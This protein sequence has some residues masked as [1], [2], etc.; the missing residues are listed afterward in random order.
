MSRVIALVTCAELP[1]GDAD[2]RLLI[3]PLARIGIEAVPA[4]WDD[5]GVDWAAFDLAIIRSC[6]DYP[7]R[8]TEFLEWAAGV[9]CVANPYR[10]LEWNTHKRYLSELAGAGIPIVPTQ[11]VEA[12]DCWVPAS[13]EATGR[14]VIKPAVSL[15]ARDSGCYEL[16][17]TV[18]LRLAEQHVQRIQMSGRTVMIQP[19]LSGI[20]IYGETSLVYFGRHISHAVRKGAVL[21]GPDAGIDNLLV[22]DDRVLRRKPPDVAELIV[23]ERALD[24]VPGSRDQLLYARVDIV[25]GDDGAPCHYGTRAHRAEFFPRTRA[26]GGRALRGGNLP[27]ARIA[28]TWQCLFF[29]G[30]QE[31][32]RHGGFIP[33]NRPLKD[34]G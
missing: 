1:D 33:R 3:E 32:G 20:D 10:V 26:R 9:G 31:C 27:D 7:K 21:D 23:A 15:G 12:E 22:T 11:W 24:L 6:W 2:T 14:C 18:Q 29:G 25:P 8:R 16:S 28:T 19:Y 4:V 5:P 13:L 17:D 30:R 34:G